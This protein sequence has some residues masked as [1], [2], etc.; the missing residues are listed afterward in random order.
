MYA[1]SLVL[2]KPLNRAGLAEL[3]GKATFTVLL[4]PRFGYAA[5][6]LA[7]NLTHALGVAWMYFRLLHS[8]KLVPP[9]ASSNDSNRP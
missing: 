4:F 8:R 7:L 5:V 3:V 6:L 2:L 1:A 9:H